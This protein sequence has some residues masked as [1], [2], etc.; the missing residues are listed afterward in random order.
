MPN[1]QRPTAFTMT[2]YCLPIIL[3]LPLAACITDDDPETPQLTVPTTYTFARDGQST[4]SFSGQTTRLRMATELTSAM[5]DFEETTTDQLLAMYR[6]E[7]PG[8]GDVNPFFDMGL[9]QAEQSVRSKVAAS[10]DYFSANT[11]EGTAIKNQFEDW[12]TQQVN[13]VFPNEEVLAEPGVAGQLADGE[14][15]RYVNEEGL[16]YDQLVTKGLLGALAL[17]QVLN[18]YLSP[19]VLDQADRRA[20]N[21]AGTVEDGENYTYMEHRWDEAY[22]YVYGTSPNPANPNATL[23]DNDAFLYKY[24]GRVEGD[25]SFVGTAET[26]FQAFLRGRAAIVEDEYELRDEQIAILQKELS[27]LVGIRAVYY[28]QQAKNALNQANPDYGT[29]FHDLSEGYGFIYSLRFTRQPGTNVPYFGRNEVDDFLT[30]LMNDGENGLWDVT[31]KTLD[32]LS[33]SIAMPF[34]FTVAQAANNEL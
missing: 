27:A 8:G 12:L 2:R 1:Q 28:L 6:N 34:D 13:E 18:N 22:G 16:E 7:A 26:I 11:A 4:V 30:K 5:M 15:V 3:L 25:L 19:A 21:T 31:P 20:E 14:S 17:D 29:A 9:N 23:G 10:Q 32:E 24:I 33:E